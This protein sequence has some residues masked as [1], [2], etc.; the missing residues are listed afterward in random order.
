MPDIPRVSDLEVDKE[1]VEANG[2]SQVIATA[3]KKA[4][5]FTDVLTIT[6]GAH[7]KNLT[8]GEAFT[9]PEEWCDAISG[10]SAKATVKV[11]TFN[12]STSIGSKTAELTITVPESVVPV[13]NDV[14]ITEAVAAVTKA[15]GNRFVQNL[16]QLNVGVDASGVYGS[17]IKSYS[18][19][20]DGVNYIQQAFTSNVIK[21][22]GKLGIAVKVTDSRG[23]SAERTF[24]DVTI[25]E[26]MLPTVAMDYIHCDSDGTQNSSGTSTKVTI[27]GKVS[28][29]EGQN[30]KTLKLYYKKTTDEKPT[31]RLV[32]V[33]DWDFTVDVII[34]N[35]DPTVTYE[36]IAELTDK[37]NVDS[38]ERSRVI[39]GVPVISRLAGGK[40]VALFGEAEEEGFIV[41]GEKPSNLTGNVF[42]GI[43]EELLSMCSQSLG[44]DI[45][46][47]VF[48]GGE[49]S[50]MGSE[51]F[52]KFSIDL[53]YPVGRILET[54]SADDDPNVCYPW[55]TWERY[56]NG[57]T[58]VGVDES[59][60]DFASAGLELGE[61]KHTLTVAEMPSHNHGFTVRGSAYSTSWI[62][63]FQNVT[64][65]AYSTG[66]TGG[67]Q[68]HN[69]I[70]PSVTVYRW[71]RVG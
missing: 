70:Q 53:M 60:T 23:R 41:K 3:T 35:T 59:D 29:V 62:V 46:D 43:D 14:G 52:L 33:S 7:T 47:H 5:A 18:V 48:P 51:G 28:S 16:S 58:T 69:N 68:A 17:T 22:A 21:T 26:Y 13:I 20:L 42:V 50:D 67:S 39:T 1:T 36:Y 37:I 49:I 40:G 4:T 19:T 61:K 12:G 2:K 9:I 38:P 31:E 25:I 56:G 24:D 54:T 34:N 66:N 57:R 63:D 55:Q 8:S 44:A 32:N 6:L 64:G 27:T 10:T 30:T 45:V 15:F 65:Q 11:E 71:R